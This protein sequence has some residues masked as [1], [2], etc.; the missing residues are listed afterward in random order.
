MVAGVDSPAVISDEQLVDDDE[1]EVGSTYS[2][3]SSCISMI[4]IL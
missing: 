2:H 4:L 3:T 1:L